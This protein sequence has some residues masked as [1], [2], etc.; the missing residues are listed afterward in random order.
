MAMVL[1]DETRPSV[2]ALMARFD[3]GR[4]DEADAEVLWL[5]LAFPLPPPVRTIQS[6]IG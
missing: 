6:T 3:E 4:H 2:A 5:N 1:T